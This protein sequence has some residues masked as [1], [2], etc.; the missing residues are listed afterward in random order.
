VLDLGLSLGQWFAFDAV[1][2]EQDRFSCLNIQTPTTYQIN[3]GNFLLDPNNPK[4]GIVGIDQQ[5]SSQDTNWALQAIAEGQGML[6]DSMAEHILGNFK[7]EKGDGQK[8]ED[9]LKAGAQQMLRVIAK[10]LGD[11]GVTQVAVYAGLMDTI[12]KP[13]LQRLALARSLASKMT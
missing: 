8:M 9:S 10:K 13:L 3:T 4:K 7:L 6:F 2:S 1:I 11:N 12:L 5:V